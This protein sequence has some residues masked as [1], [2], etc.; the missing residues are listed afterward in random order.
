MSGP[1]MDMGG[2]S[3]EGN[4]RSGRR[5]SSGI[6]FALSSLFWVP[7]LTG[8]LVIGTNVIKANQV[9]HL[10]RDVGHMWAYGVDFSQTSG[11]NLLA[12]IAQGLNFNIAGTGNGVVILSNVT[13]IGNN[14]CLAA[15]FQAN[16]TSCPNLNQAVFTRRV[17]VGNS[18]LRNSNFGTPP[19]AI[20][21][22]SGY[23]G[24][25]DYCTNTSDR[26]NSFIQL[27]PLAAGDTSSLTETYFISPE[28][29]WTGIMTGTAEYSYA[30]F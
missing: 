26:A 20:I 22:T 2:N 21:G 14:Q 25:S 29:D 30:I 16:T 4:S 12:K 27:L 9:T 24:S 11:Q 28:L 19:A 6:E 7:L 3:M 23:I 8:T 18:S 13:Y 1:L 17:V 15:G 5:G 10:C